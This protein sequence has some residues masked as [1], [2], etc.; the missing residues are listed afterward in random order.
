[1]LTK[2]LIICPLIFIAGF[3]DAVAG[4]GGLVSLPAYMITGIPV[5]NC[6]ATNKMSSFM[7]TSVTTA[8]YARKGFIPWKIGIVCV[9]CA[10]AGSAL[11][12]KAS[13]LVPDN[14]LKTILMIIIPL[15]GI[16]VITRKGNLETNTV[17]SDIAAL[18]ISAFVAFFI[19]AY[20]GFY[21]PGTGVFLILLLTYF[22]GM[23][24]T[25]ANGL[26]KV[27]NLSTNIA[28]LVVFLINGQVLLP[29]GAVA[30][31][32]NIAGN[33]IGATCFEKNSSKIVKPVMIAVLSIF[34]VKLMLETAF[35]D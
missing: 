18:F 11:G 4:G 2:Y 34:F 33:Y 30:G 24:L 32:F 20:D 10:L 9:P 13:L 17:R 26:T 27:I 22:A 31:L 35:F 28:A 6:I 5:H 3:I 1:M 7:G 29:L 25:T 8:K 19:G 21:G 16:Y 14:I 12:A 23:K 15:T